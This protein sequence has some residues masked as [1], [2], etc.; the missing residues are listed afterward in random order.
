MSNQKPEKRSEKLEVRLTYSEKRALQLEAKSEGS[1]VS[2]LVRAV[3]E[4]H[5]ESQPYFETAL[6]PMRRHPRSALAGLL[7]VIGSLGI[8]F[9]LSPSA[10]TEPLRVEMLGKMVSPDPEVTQVSRFS[11]NVDLNETGEGTQLLMHG[12]RPFHVPGAFAQPHKIEVS[13]LQAD[14]EPDQPLVLTLRVVEQESG[15][16]LVGAE[17]T[18]TLKQ[19]RMVNFDFAADSGIRYTIAA[20]VIGE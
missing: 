20:Q 11:A 3:L 5:I 18:A 6:Q 9:S 4:R 7:A 1:S 8:A 16:E 14:D 13:V 2:E 17:P 19:G 10:S 15:L 12:D